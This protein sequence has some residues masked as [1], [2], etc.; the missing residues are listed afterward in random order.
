MKSRGSRRL[1]KRLGLALAIAALAVPA[2]QAYPLVDA[3]S[4]KAPQARLYADD[5]HAV[6]SAPVQERIYADDLHGQVT[7]SPV[8]VPVEPES[9]PMSRSSGF[10][11]SDAGIG[12]GI[13]FML[14]GLGAAILAARQTR[15]SRLAA[16]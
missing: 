6:A 14:L 3:P 16:I 8:S 4:A 7:S 12:A 2:A 5:L 11:W 10:D 1:V 15:R 13:A 9:H